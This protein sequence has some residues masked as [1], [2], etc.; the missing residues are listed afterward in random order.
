M[1][2]LVSLLTDVTQ[3]TKYTHKYKYVDIF[4]QL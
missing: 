3:L 2:A 4:G 1:C